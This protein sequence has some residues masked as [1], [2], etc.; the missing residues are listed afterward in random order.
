MEYGTV[1]SYIATKVSIIPQPSKKAY[2]SSSQ[3]KA[4]P[5]QRHCRNCRETG[6]NAH[7]YKIDKEEASKSNASVLDIYSLA[8]NK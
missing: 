3:E 8:S 6:H 2:G 5:T 7:I 4:Q 1:A